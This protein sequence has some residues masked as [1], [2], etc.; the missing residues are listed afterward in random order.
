MTLQP[1]QDLKTALL[2]D[3]VQWH[4]SESPGPLIYLGYPVPI[5]QAHINKYL[6][7]L[8]SKIQR[9]INIHSQRTLSVL[10]KAVIVNSLILSRLWHTLWVLSPPES[11]F[12]KV[13]SI[14]K[15]FI[16]PNKPAPSWRLF[17][18]PKDQGGLGIID[19]GTQAITFQ[20]RHVQNMLSDKPSFGRQV[21][22]SAVQLY[23]HSPSPFSVFLSPN[24][25]LKPKVGM[26]KEFHYP[27][28]TLQ[29]LLKAFARLPRF[30]WDYNLPEL[31]KPPIE[32]FLASPIEWWLEAL[33]T[34]RRNNPPTASA[35]QDWKPTKHHYGLW[36]EELLQVVQG[37]ITPQASLPTTGPRS[38]PTKKLIRRLQK[39]STRFCLQVKHTVDIPDLSLHKILG[40]IKLQVGKKDTISF[41]QASTQQLR[42]VPTST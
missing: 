7:D 34:R 10:G 32:L 24:Y 37:T 25:Y 35:S 9:S 14:I 23:T 17:C 33:P 6:D 39:K 26:V 3:S 20:L 31:S 11:W 18:S 4:D 30:S 27:S 41:V 1:D 40:T 12:K 8:L 28:A 38:G 15:P 5:C 21:M 22:L 42:I 29:S 13:V 19:P 36:T 16:L 2:S